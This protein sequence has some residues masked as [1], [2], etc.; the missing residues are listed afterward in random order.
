MGKY[1]PVA[2]GRLIEQNHHVATTIVVP[3]GADQTNSPWIPGSLDG[4]N[5]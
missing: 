5:G 1:L 4:M 3:C 2:C